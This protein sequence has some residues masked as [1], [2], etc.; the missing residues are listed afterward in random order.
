LIPWADPI[1]LELIYRPGLTQYSWELILSA[2]PIPMGIDSW[3]DP[4]GLELICGPGLTQ[5][6]W[7][8]IL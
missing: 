4:I 3:A 8:L 2:H 1:G 6:S 5:Y 7:E